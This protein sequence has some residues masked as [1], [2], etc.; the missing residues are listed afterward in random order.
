MK[1]TMLSEV[2]YQVHAAPDPRS[3]GL[4]APARCRIREARNSPALCHP[5]CRACVGAH[6]VLHHVVEVP[7]VEMVLG[8][9]D[10]P[11][12]VGEEVLDERDAMPL[13]GG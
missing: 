13:A 5:A 8:R 6:H 2:T 10:E 12:L 3:R 7:N 9:V 4:S 1:F 11:E